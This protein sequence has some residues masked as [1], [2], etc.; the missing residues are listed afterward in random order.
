MS[1][2]L[3][4]RYDTAETPRKVSHGFDG[5]VGTIPTFEECSE[6]HFGKKSASAAGPWVSMWS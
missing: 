6:V 4:E 1:L 3:R 5:R 2:L